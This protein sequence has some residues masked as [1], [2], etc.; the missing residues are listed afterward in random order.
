[1]G[2]DGFRQVWRNSNVEEPET[3]LSVDSCHHDLWTN[4]NV[5]FSPI[6]VQTMVQDQTFASL[7]KLSVLGLKSPKTAQG[8]VSEMFP[9]ISLINQVLRKEHTTALVI[10]K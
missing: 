1:M 2:L 6:Q 9:N 8:K 4:P 7:L 10:T 3:K 5:Q